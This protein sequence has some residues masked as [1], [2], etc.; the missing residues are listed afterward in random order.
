M[1]RRGGK[2]MRTQMLYML[3]CACIAATSAAAPEE[4]IRG[5]FIDPAPSS[6]PPKQVYVTQNFEVGKPHLLSWKMRVEGSKT[7]RFRAKFAGVSIS[8]IDKSGVPIAVQSRHTHCYLT[9]SEQDAWV[10]ADIPTG[11]ARVQVA[12]SIVSQDPL[13][14]RFW[15]GDFKLTPVHPTSPIPA[16]MAA[17]TLVP[18]LKDGTL[19]TARLS[20]RDAN[21]N[22][23]LPP[24]TFGFGAG[25]FGFHL[26][27]A[28][29]NRIFM[30]PGAY[31]V[32]ATKGFEYG[33]VRKTITLAE[34][35]HATLPLV[36][37]RSMDLSRRGWYSGDHHV[38]LF[39]H[40]GSIY[41]FINLDDVY[42]IGRGEGLDYVGF[43]GE[44]LVAPAARLR[45]ASGFLGWVKPELTR[46]LWGHL[47]PIGLFEWPRMERHGDLWPMSVD[48]MEAAVS[49]GGAIAYAHPYGFNDASLAKVLSDP[50]TGHAAREL[51]MA[52]ALGRGFTIDM[53]TEEGSGA[54]FGMKLRDYFRLLNLGFRLGVSGSTDIH[55]DQGRQPIGA[56]RTYVHAARLA[57]PAVAQAYREGRTFATNGPLLLLSAGDA[58]PG[59]VIK[60]NPGESIDCAVEAFSHWGIDRVTLWYNGEAVRNWP[61]PG[62]AAI[63][64]RHKFKVPASG[65]ILA[66]A[67]GPAATELVH[68]PEGAAMA[69]GQVAITSPLY[70][71]VPGRPLR[72]DKDAAEYFI[73]WIEAA[74][75]GFEAS[76]AQA[77]AT[78]SALPPEIREQVLARFARAHSIFALKTR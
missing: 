25:R 67:R 78:G 3:W 61:A 74:R 14:G 75:T 48:W 34:G 10:I 9:A 58:Q 76:S 60:L 44:D 21:G 11:T 29:L 27:S 57:W 33:P 8:F 50:Q 39:R 64:G 42:S 53:L 22:P 52:A 38:H 37:R 31:E 68:Q 17:L 77:A 47:C 36:L 41:P 63:Q 13:P 7:W 49:A 69:G 16:G 15:V 26:S 73:R 12:F 62:A 55:V 46:D 20:I 66:M 1:L 30:P 71:E 54:D 23:V 4:S 19:T 2:R 28:R 40:G 5:F 72:P 35:A 45:E 6:A 43:M 24:Y 70:V 18:T 56:M 32:T 51:P 59:D 65:W